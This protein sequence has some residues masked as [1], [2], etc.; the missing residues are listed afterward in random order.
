MHGVAPK[1]EGWGV[2]RVIYKNPTGFNSR[3][4]RN[5]KMEKAKEII[6]EL[7]A[8]VEAYS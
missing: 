5:E 6:D 1:K 3:M 7:E 8:D 4:N 2:T